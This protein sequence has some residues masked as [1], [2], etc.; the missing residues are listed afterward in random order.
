MIHHSLFKHVDHVVQKCLVPQ[1]G[2]T[3]SA[4]RR[5]DGEEVCG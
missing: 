1:L 4:D 3:L 2:I 5:L